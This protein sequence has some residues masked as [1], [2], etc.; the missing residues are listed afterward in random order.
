LAREGEAEVFHVRRDETGVSIYFGLGR[1]HGIEKGSKLL[2]LDP[3]RRPLGQIRVERV[4]DTD[5]V[6]RVDP[7]S[8]V[9]PGCLVKSMAYPT[10]GR[11]ALEGPIH[12]GPSAPP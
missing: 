9:K 10:R 7:L 11:L 6:A 4:S 1:R 3:K 5:A 2:L 12:K 8:E